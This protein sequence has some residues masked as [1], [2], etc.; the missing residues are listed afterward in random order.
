VTESF[1]A[2]DTKGTKE[3]NSFTAKDAKDAKE[4]K[5]EHREQA[6]SISRSAPARHPWQ[7][8]C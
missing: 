2:K 3:N 6:A 5:L 1:T 4:S 8:C 7:G